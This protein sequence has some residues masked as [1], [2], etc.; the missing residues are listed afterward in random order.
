MKTM[1]K[2][3]AVSRPDTPS[4]SGHPRDYKIIVNGQERTVST[5]ALSFEAVVSLA[6]DPVPTGPYVLITV[7]FRH[8]DQKPAEGTLTAGNS[9]KIKNRTVFSVTAT[10]KS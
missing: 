1:K 9:V 2:E 3:L 8:A 5:D 7:S 6:F 10:D 4:E